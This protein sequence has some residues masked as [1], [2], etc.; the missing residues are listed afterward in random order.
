MEK[1]YLKWDPNSIDVEASEVDSDYI[2]QF[3][4][5]TEPKNPDQRFLTVAVIDS[6]VDDSHPI[7]EGIE[8]E[9]YDLTGKSHKLRD[10]IGHGTAASSLIVQHCPFVKK[11]IDIRIFNGKG[12][13]SSQALSDAYD[14]LL[15]K[16][17]EIDLANFSLGT[18]RKVD[19]ID[20]RHNQLNKK[21]VR[22]VSASGN[23]GEDSGGSPASAKSAF[24]VGALTREGEM[25][26]FS[27]SN[28]EYNTP[29]I[30]ALGQNIKLARAKGTSMGVPLD[31]EWTMAAGTSFSCPITLA[32]IGNYMV[33]NGSF[34]REDFKATADDLPETDQDGSGVLNLENAIA[35][36]DNEVD[37]ETSGTIESSMGV[38]V[39]GDSNNLIWLKNNWLPAGSYKVE[40]MEDKLKI[41]G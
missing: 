14:L 31:E 26:D 37:K 29:S 40:I 21:G 5:W 20:A 28:P 2:R 6:G 3:H 9:H 7:F 16:A 12:Q 10:S 35:A 30:S 1:V 17:N 25:T 18:S 24:S 15:E 13:T 36:G 8:V 11:I 27:S 22:T 32:A 39:Y 33:S 23:S 34:S 4:N 19:F 38:Q 41:L